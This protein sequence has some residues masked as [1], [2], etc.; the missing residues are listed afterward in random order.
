M[1]TDKREV[2]TAFLSRS[3]ATLAA[4]ADVL[5][6]DTEAARY[7]RLAERI[8]EAWRTE[9][10]DDTDRTTVDTQASYVRALSYELAPEKL[11]DA[12]AARLAELIEAAGHHLGTGL[13]S[14]A[15][16]LPALA[17][18]GHADLAYQVLPPAHLTLLA[19]HARPGSHHDL[20][21]VGRRR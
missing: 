18:T 20:G 11:R 19:R 13:L 2:G 17:D 7:S 8:K 12:V 6:H 14:T 9:F 16:L 4:I 10:L 3:T 21:G 1:K 15:D 5:G